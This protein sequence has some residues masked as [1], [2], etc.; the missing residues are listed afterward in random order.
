M[1]IIQCPHFSFTTF[2]EEKSQEYET[3]TI[4]EYNCENLGLIKVD[5]EG[6]E[7]KVLRG[8]IGTIIRNNYPPILFELFPIGHYNMTEEKYNSLINF[9]Q[10]LGYEI[11][12]NWGDGQTHLAIHENNENNE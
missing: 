6:M 11:K 3:H 2:E 5:V 9:L 12:W 1:P 8:A 4:D 7:E 10:E